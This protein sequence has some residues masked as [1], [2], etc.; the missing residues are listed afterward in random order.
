MAT[1][2]AIKYTDGELFILNQLLLPQESVFEEIKG[3]QDGW[4]AIKTMKVMMLIFTR[5][6]T[7]C[8][9][10]SFMIT[11]VETLLCKTTENNIPIV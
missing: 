7:M 11:L 5:S 1:L 6:Y 4:N 10:H 2:E 8:C 3:V 9:S